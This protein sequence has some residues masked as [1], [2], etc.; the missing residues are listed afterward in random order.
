MVSPLALRRFGFGSIAALA[1]VLV[2]SVGQSLAAGRL[3]PTFGRDGRVVTNFGS[4]EDQ[5]NDVA[6]QPDGKILVVGLASPGGE[7][8][9]GTG[10][11]VF[12]VV[13]YRSDGRLDPTFSGDGK[14]ILNFHPDPDG[15]SL[16]YEEATSLALQQ[17]GRIVIAGELSAGPEH[18]DRHVVVVRLMPNGKLDSTF[19]GDGKVVTRVICEPG[20]CPAK[21]PYSVSIQ[22]DDKILVAGCFDCFRYDELFLLLRY[23]PNGRLDHTFG[24]GGVVMTDVTPEGDI[25][26]DVVIRP[27]GRILALSSTFDVVRYLPDGRIDESFA[28]Q[29]IA[30]YHLGYISGST[31]L[32]RQPDGKL[33]IAGHVHDPDWLGLPPQLPWSVALM[34]LLPGGGVDD[35]FGGDGIVVTDVGGSVMCEADE[36]TGVVIQAN[37]KILAS[38]TACTPGIDFSVLRYRRN[39]RLDRTFG[40]GGKLA[41][42]LHGADFGLASWLGA[43]KLVVAGRGGSRY[44]FA[45]ARYRLD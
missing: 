10:D 6:V 4:T 9:D 37:G 21:H 34:R 23:R 18:R 1:F 16:E 40:E 42:D 43:G 29:G 22:P 13:R 24:D 2:P 26:V 12:I 33:V 27:S 14:V 3:D 5:A 25:A 38:G 15:S 31:D 19:G 20:F 41:T 17:D 28:Q 35:T 44:D 7:I 45:V 30:A 11:L 32:V 39:G 8:S 36:A